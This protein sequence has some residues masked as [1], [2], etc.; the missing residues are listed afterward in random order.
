MV[1]LQENRHFTYTHFR[2]KLKRELRRRRALSLNIER[3]SSD[4]KVDLKNEQYRSRDGSRG[5]HSRQSSRDRDTSNMVGGSR[6]SSRDRENGHKSSDGSG[7][8]LVRASSSERYSSLPREKTRRDRSK[9]REAAMLGLER[10]R[11]EVISAGRSLIRSRSKERELGLLLKD[12]NILTRQSGDGNHGNADW[13]RQAAH[14]DNEKEFLEKRIEELHRQLADER[15]HSRR[16]KLTV[17]RLQRELARQKSDSSLQGVRDGLMKELER[18]RMLR[19]EAEQRVQEMTVESDCQKRLQHLQEEFHKMEDMVRGMLTYKTKVDQLKSEKQK[20]ASTYENSITKCRSHISNLEHENMLLITELKKMES[21]AS[22]GQMPLS[23]SE[24]SDKS[25]VLLERLKQ[26]EAENSSLVLENEQQRQQYEKCLDQIANQVVQALLTQKGLREECMKLQTRVH[27]L[28]FQNRQL[29]AMFQQRLK[30]SSDSLLPS[31]NNSKQKGRG[32]SEGRGMSGGMSSHEGSY[33]SLPVQSQFSYQPPQS[34]PQYKQ[35]RMS[36]NSLTQAYPQDTPGNMQQINSYPSQ[37]APGN[38]AQGGGIFSQDSIDSLHSICSDYNDSNFAFESGGVPQMSSPPPW[39]RDKLNFSPKMPDFDQHFLPTVSSSGSASS[40]TGAPS[41]GGQQG[42]APGAPVPGGFNP[43]VIQA[44]SSPVNT[45]LSGLDGNEGIDD[46]PN[47]SM[48]VAGGTPKTLNGSEFSFAITPD[49]KFPNERST[50]EKADQSKSEQCVS[51]T[52]A[53]KPVSS[54]TTQS[55]IQTEFPATQGSPKLIHVGVPL[56]GIPREIPA[57]IPGKV[58]TIGAYLRQLRNVMTDQS[59]SGST[60]DTTTFTTSATTL[61]TVNQQIAT[62]Q[63]SSLTALNQPK[64]EAQPIKKALQ[65]EEDSPSNDGESPSHGR[66][67]Q[68]AKL[69]PHLLNTSSSLSVSPGKQLLQLNDSFDEKYRE[70]PSE[71]EQGAARNV[72]VHFQKVDRNKAISPGQEL[73]KLNDSFNEKYLLDTKD[74]LPEIRP[75]FS[76]SSEE[77]SDDIKRKHLSMASSVSLNDL[78]ERGRLQDLDS[79][80]DSGDS[81]TEDTTDLA[82]QNKDFTS[83]DTLKDETCSM[84]SSTDTTVT[85]D[86]DVNMDDLMITSTDSVISDTGTLTRSKDSSMD[87]QSTN[88]SCSMSPKHRRPSSL[89]VEKEAENKDKPQYEEKSFLQPDKHIAVVHN[90]PKEQRAVI[91]NNIDNYQQFERTPTVTMATYM[92]HDFSNKDSNQPQPPPR[93]AADD[94]PPPT[95]PRRD[96][97]PSMEPPPRPPK[98]NKALIRERLSKSIADA[99]VKKQHAQQND[100]EKSKDLNENV[101]T[102]DSNKKGAA[103]ANGHNITVMNVESVQMEVT[104]PFQKD[105]HPLWSSYHSD[106]I[107]SVHITKIDKSDPTKPRSMDSSTSSTELFLNEK[108]CSK[109]DG[110][111][112]LT[113]NSTPDIMDKFRDGTKYMGGKMDPFEGGNISRSSHGDSGIINSPTSTDSCSFQ[114]PP[115]L[116]R[117]RS[118]SRSSSISS[119]TSVSSIDSDSMG[120]VRDIKNYFEHETKSRSQSPTCRHKRHSKSPSPGRHISITQSDSYT[121]DSLNT[122]CSQSIHTLPKAKTVQ[123]QTS[124]KGQDNFVA[125]VKPDDEFEPEFIRKSRLSRSSSS[126]EIEVLPMLRIIESGSEAETLQKANVRK[127][128]TSLKINPKMS[129]HML[130]RSRKSKHEARQFLDNVKALKI[131]SKS[132]KVQHNTVVPPLGDLKK[133]SSKPPGYLYMA[134]AESIDS[135]LSSS[136]TDSEADSPPVDFLSK[137]RHREKINVELPDWNPR[138]TAEEIRKYIPPSPL[139]QTPTDERTSSEQWFLQFSKEDIK[140]HTSRIPH[141]R[142]LSAPGLGITDR[143]NTSS[144]VDPMSRSAAFCDAGHDL[145]VQATLEKF[146]H[147]I[148]VLCKECNNISIT[149]LEPSPKKIERDQVTRNAQDDI[150]SA[151]HNFAISEQC[152]E[153]MSLGERDDITPSDPVGSYQIADLSQTVKELQQSLDS[154]AEIKQDSDNSETVH[155]DNETCTEADGDFSW[156]TPEAWSNL[157]GE[158]AKKVV[159]KNEVPLRSDEDSSYSSNSTTTVGTSYLDVKSREAALDSVVDND[160]DNEQ[161]SDDDSEAEHEI[162]GYIIEKLRKGVNGKQVVH[163][164]HREHRIVN[165]HQFFTRYGHQEQQAVSEFKFLDQF[166]TNSSSE[167][168]DASK[169]LLDNNHDSDCEVEVLQEQLC[170]NP[171]PLNVKPESLHVKPES[172]H[173]KPESLHVKPEGLH[174]KPVSLHVKPEGLHVK[175]V[176]LHVKPESL[177]VKPES[178]HVKPEGLHVKPV[179]LHVKP[180]SLHVKPEGLYVKPVSLHVKPE[181]LIDSIKEDS[182]FLFLDQQSSNIVAFQSNSTCKLKNVNVDFKRKTEGLKDLHFHRTETDKNSRT[183]NSAQGIQPADSVSSIASDIVSSIVSSTEHCIASDNQVPDSKDTSHGDT[184]HGDTSH[185]DT[186]HGDTSHRDSSQ[187]G[188]LTR[189]N[190]KL[191]DTHSRL[192]HKSITLLK[193]E[194]DSKRLS[195]YSF[196]SEQYVVCDNVSQSDS[197]GE[198]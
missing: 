75:K 136:D 105:G 60:T 109:D 155:K 1:L 34:Y 9:D 135:F 176:S 182:K 96:R 49:A 19:V 93:V 121:N 107:P 195:T 57:D 110:Y 115:M 5:R 45:A 125:E 23:K 59:S 56:K 85:I 127:P 197:C 188:N 62:P 15:Q 174:V 82:S 178:L 81:F 28:E 10:P 35:T 111:S 41:G 87:T 77:D 104:L 134:S 191:L 7:P 66:E 112:T 146:E 187:R 71:F 152:K 94:T 162:E 139:V 79:S 184:S 90:P 86:G 32:G 14:L 63:L 76:D 172:L 156:M 52:S 24:D 183:S 198:A 153:T 20:L 37:D 149:P 26:L 98:P 177:H 46:T 38:M 180:E 120:K 147:E 157:G 119:I 72:T 48:E 196:G 108:C 159:P 54:V 114:S 103:M 145:G 137:W 18:E 89:S 16:E 27:D 138:Q 124:L 141:R 70:L 143:D 171:G 173:V 43:S 69:D 140:K 58:D 25:K 67:S 8:H 101:D 128:P 2:Q 133:P 170:L 13:R 92:N 100:N 175:P 39:L 29:N 131:S 4:E 192:Q 179:S 83:R 185:G 33:H 53:I 31:Y 166:S 50:T 65:K 3:G 113:G 142:H 165:F 21:D 42:G 84:Q 132:P 80:S 126:P 118:R 91:S 12:N 106:I 47:S 129:P 154:L 73:L 17:A 150:F 163:Q 194:T 30:F 55:R 22:Q 160:A 74:G 167:E 88:S 169:S 61:T 186:S 181:G 123:N 161:D 40:I 51:L 122:H 95:P 117:S 97:K 6:H 151:S 78:L 164:R 99:T 44:A 68:A 116:D 130:L 158:S 144:N 189:H 11:P 168:D 190:V 148:E 36:P 102:K 193:Q 64:Q